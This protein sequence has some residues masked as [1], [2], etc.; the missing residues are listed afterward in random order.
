MGPQ[1]VRNVEA[2]TDQ[3]AALKQVHQEK[4]I[5]LAAA[6]TTYKEYTDCKRQE[7]PT[8]KPCELVMIYA[9]NMKLKV[10]CCKLDPKKGPESPGQSV[11]H[12]R[13]KNPHSLGTPTKYLPEPET[14][15]FD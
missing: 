4:K 5:T 3:A 13:G 1:K 10:P 2:A 7:G 9:C 15:P 6:V 14:P 8:Y 11:G 12:P